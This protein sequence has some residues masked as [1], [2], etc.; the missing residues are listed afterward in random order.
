MIIYPN[1]Y[2]KEKLVFPKWVQL[3][4]Y[5]RPE[6]IVDTHYGELSY[7]E[8]LKLECDLLNSIDDRT[9]CID[10]H[11]YEP[12]QNRCWSGR[13]I[14]LFCN[15]LC[16]SKGCRNQAYKEKRVSSGYLLYF[17]KECLKVEK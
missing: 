7:F 1:K 9:A 4:V 14:A 15:P 2:K 5:D 10:E 11:K 12:S 8:Y 17:C 16:C 13:K 6:I 3:K